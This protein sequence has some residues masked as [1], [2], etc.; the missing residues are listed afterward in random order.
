MACRTHLTN[1]GIGLAHADLFDTDG[2]VGEVAQ[3]LLV[4]RREPDLRQRKSDPTDD[5]DKESLK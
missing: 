4:Q 2:F 5:G 1:D 3:P